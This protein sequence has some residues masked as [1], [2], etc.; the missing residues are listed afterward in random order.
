[1]C[2]VIPHRSRSIPLLRVETGWEMY[3]GARCSDLAGRPEHQDRDPAP[4]M[5]VEGT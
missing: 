2:V 1:M 3:L 4:P 5:E